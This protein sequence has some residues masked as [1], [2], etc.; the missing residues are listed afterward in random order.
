VLPLGTLNHFARDLGIPLEL[1]E[2]AKVLATGGVR[3]VDVAE[4]NGHRFVN[5]SSVGFYPHV[6]RRRGRLRSWLGK[7]LAMAWSVLEVLWRLPRMRLRL[8]ADDVEAP[9]VTPFL[10]VGNNR[11]DAAL[12]ADRHREALDRGE[13][14]VYVARWAGRLAFMRVGLRWFLGR[15]RHEDLAELSARSVNV[16]SRRSLLHVAADGE[17]L[18]LAPPLRYRIHPRALRVIAPRPAS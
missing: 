4:V 13:L 18:R 8:R 9:V 6:V 3:R 10:F 7:W 1:G 2:A 5:N 16:E 15:G 11:Y 12:L 17:V 14:R